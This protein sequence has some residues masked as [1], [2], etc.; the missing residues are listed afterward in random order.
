MHGKISLV[1][2]VRDDD[3]TE[4]RK[5]KATEFATEVSMNAFG[6]LSVVPTGAGVKSEQIADFRRLLFQKG[7]QDFLKTHRKFLE[8]DQIKYLEE[9][10]KCYGDL[11]KMMEIGSKFMQSSKDRWKTGPVACRGDLTDAQCMDEAIVLDWSFGMFTRPQR[12]KWAARFPVQTME[13][14]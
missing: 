13:P 3:C 14:S 11:P 4:G 10:N 12:K 6:Y 2:L 7:T 5:R 9:A 8:P 1:V